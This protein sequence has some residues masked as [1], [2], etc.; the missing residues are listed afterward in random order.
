MGTSSSLS[1]RMKD[2]SVKAIYC[3]Y[4]GY[5]EHHMP[6]LV[7]NY[8]TQ[9]KAEALISLGDLSVLDASIE[10]PEGSDF[11]HAED[12]YCVA[13]GRDR[14]DANA[15]ARKYN[16]VTAALQNEQQD[17]NYHFDGANWILIK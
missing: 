17:Y 14:G 1:V 3:H 4:D 15:E 7:K 8:G 16:S 11:Y 6:I 10:K 2:G 5:P 9:E 13:Y 12:G